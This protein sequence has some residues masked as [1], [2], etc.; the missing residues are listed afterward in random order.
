MMGR[1]DY[2]KRWE[3]RKKDYEAAGFKVGVK[4]FTSEDDERGGLDSKDIRK[5]A[6]RI[7][8]LL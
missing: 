8:T 3:R 2:S 1:E 7:Q 4:L 6:E 5:I